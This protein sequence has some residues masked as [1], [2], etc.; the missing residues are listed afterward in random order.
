MMA[1]LLLLCYF[2]FK[3]SCKLQRLSDFNNQNKSIFFVSLTFQ[4]NFAFESF[5]D[6]T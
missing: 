6:D 1:Y 3:I 2:Y 5:Q 4:N